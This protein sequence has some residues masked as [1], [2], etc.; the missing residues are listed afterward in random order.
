VAFAGVLGSLPRRG[1]GRSAQKFV[2]NLG[3]VPLSTAVAAVV[4]AALGGRP[5]QDL[6]LLLAPLTSAAVTLF[7]VN[8]GLVAAAVAIDRRRPLLATWGGSFL[9]TVV[10][11]L[12]GLSMTVA[13][14][15]VSEVSIGW[16]LLI[17]AP[18]SW[19]LVEYYQARARRF[20]ERSTP[21]SEYA[22][23]EREMTLTVTRTRAG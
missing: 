3:A 16:V 6:L 19:L 9:W 10:P 22:D 11:C 8:T 12:G 20:A 21:P 23:Y 2:F 17:G 4:F 18:P 1:S 13:M 7:L 15:A 14:Y 5:G